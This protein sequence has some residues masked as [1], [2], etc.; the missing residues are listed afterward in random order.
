[1]N[2]KKGLV[3]IILGVVLLV[4]LSG[5]SADE[6]AYTIITGD[7]IDELTGAMI[8]ITSQ[9]YEVHEGH[10]FKSDIE[11]LSM[12]DTANLTFAFKT[13]AGTKTAHIWIEFTTLV[14]GHFR[15]W[16]DVTWTTN[17]GTLVPIY[18]R[19]REASM[20]SSG[21]L[22]DKTATPVF[23]ATDNVLLNPDGLDIS[24]ATLLHHF[25]AWGK[26]EK[27]QAQGARDA[28]ELILKPDTQYAITFTS[29]G[30]SNKAQMILNW[31]E[32]TD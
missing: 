23:T 10:Y 3:S 5:C 24:S 22:E 19:K 18:N 2:T 25:I 27:L 1:M 17:T 16:E 9:H 14:G 32:H 21:L 4:G 28:E 20:N 26:K 29:S 30:G 15:I 6:A 13:M 12:A 11:D 31:Y 8:T 7:T